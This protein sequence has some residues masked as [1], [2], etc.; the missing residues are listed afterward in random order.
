MKKKCDLK[1]DE[2][3]NAQVVLATAAP[4]KFPEAVEKAG[5]SPKKNPSIEKLFSMETRYSWL[6]FATNIYLTQKL[7]CG[8]MNQGD[9][10]EK[11]LREK[12]EEITRKN[13]TQ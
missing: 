2:K 7:R 5:V 12:I 1:I 4:D 8:A 11:I 6:T 13:S 3:K 9:N 10:W